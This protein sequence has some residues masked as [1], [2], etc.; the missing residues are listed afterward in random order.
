MLRSG[1]RVRWIGPP[2]REGPDPYVVNP[3]DIGVY[4]TPDGA[5]QADG[6]VVSFPHVGGFCCPMDHVEP[7]E[8]EDDNDQPAP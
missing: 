8:D 3:G 6:L 2:Y 4:V 1:Q 7:V 5:T